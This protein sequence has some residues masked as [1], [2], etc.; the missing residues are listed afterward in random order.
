MFG[1]D[2]IV[3]DVAQ[4][5]REL[6]KR[7]VEGNLLD[8]V[9]YSEEVVELKKQIADLEIVRD[10]EKEDRA[11]ELR[12]VEHKI[13][14]ERQRSSQEATLAAQKATNEKDAAIAQ[15]R[16]EVREENLKAEKGRFETEMKFMRER[17]EH[18]VDQLRD[19]L[20]NVMEMVPKVTVDKRIR[21]DYTEGKQLEAP[22][23]AAKRSTRKK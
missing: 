8:Q 21:E 6:N 17:M 1:T 22:K 15:A 16:V 14:L 11:R 3:K 9:A 10:K 23:P 18:E 12:E 13:G 7:F 4:Q 19:L 5:L 2:P 20:G